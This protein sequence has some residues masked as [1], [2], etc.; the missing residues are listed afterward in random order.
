MPDL[1]LP[2]HEMI[3]VEGGI[4]L[5][6]DD[7]GTTNDASPAHPVQLDS[8]MI[9]KYP[10]TQALWKE[11]MGEE[12][13]P[14]FFKGDNRPVENIS[15]ENIRTF[16]ERCKE[17]TDQVYRFPTEAEWEYAALGGN[18]SQGF[19]YAGSDK[20]KEVGWNDE[21]SYGET[22]PVGLKA[23]NELGLY[24]MSGNVWEW[25]RDWYNPSYYAE[26]KAQGT[27]LNPKGPSNGVFLIIRGGCWYNLAR[28][29]EVKFRDNE[30]SSFR[31]SYI[32][33]RLALSL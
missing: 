27:V 20:L 18:R 5:M 19:L 12:H 26:C 30:H 33:F 8:Y 24:D 32:G 28:V 16:L 17:K 4:F 14:S 29:C 25:C 21:N 11:M 9:G 10:V 15:P 1:Q 23:P 31:S 3:L 2:H 6:G 7:N 13:N 22:K